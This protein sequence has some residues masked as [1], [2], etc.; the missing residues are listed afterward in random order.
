MPE[1]FFRPRARGSFSSSDN[2]R[3]LPKDFQEALVILLAHP[4]FCSSNL[5]DALETYCKSLVN[6]EGEHV[7]R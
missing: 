4:E 7:C 5:R 3:Q 1:L 2:Y 6:R